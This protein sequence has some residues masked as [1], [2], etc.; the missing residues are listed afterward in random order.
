LP[1]AASLLIATLLAI[2]PVAE[3]GLTVEAEGL[4]QLERLGDGPTCRGLKPG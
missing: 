2:A 4:S 1:T 3:A